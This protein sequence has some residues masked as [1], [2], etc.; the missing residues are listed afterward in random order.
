MPSKLR[1]AL[2]A[3]LRKSEVERELDEELPYHIDQQAGQNIRLGMNPEEVRTA[4]RKAF[5]GVEQA[6]ERSRDASGIRWIEELWQDLR[7]GLRAL[8]KRP[9]FTLI[10]ALTLASG[11]GANTAVFSV[12]NAF[13]LRPLPYPEPG[14]LVLVG[15]QE[16]DNLIGV[17]F[18]DYQDW[19][20]QSAVFDDLAFFQSAWKRQCRTGQRD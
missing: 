17:S 2:R 10:V 11:I 19:R 4:A 16:R 20:A 8:L 12:I 14:R 3:L 9:G 13:L 5:G 7:F 6:K 18:L 15:S 1:T